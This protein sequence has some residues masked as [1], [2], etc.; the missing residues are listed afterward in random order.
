M[1]IELAPVYI[2]NAAAVVLFTAVLAQHIQ[3]GN[4]IRVAILSPIAFTAW[5]MV[6]L[7]FA[8]KYLGYTPN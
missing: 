5:V 3:Q 4:V 2:A 8:E 7:W 1:N 6:A